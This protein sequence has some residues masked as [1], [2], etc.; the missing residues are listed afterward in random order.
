MLTCKG[1]SCPAT[2][3]LIRAI[4]GP[5]RESH[6][7]RHHAGRAEPHRDEPRRL[8]QPTRPNKPA[9]PNEPAKPHRGGRVRHR[10][11]PAR[12]DHHAGEP[13]VR[14]VLRY[15][16]RCRRHPRP[17]RPVHR[18]RARPAHQRLRQAVP[19]SEPGERRSRPQYGRRDRRHRR[20]QDGRFRPDRRGP[21]QPGLQRH[22]PADTGLPA[23]QP[24]L[25]ISPY[26]RPGYIDHQTLSF[27]A[28]NK[29]IEDDFLGGARLDPA[30][31]GRPDPRPDVRENASIL[32]NLAAD[33]DFSQPPRP[34]VLL[35]THPEPGPASTPG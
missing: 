5:A 13:V 11:D 30:T 27:D 35:P 14:L 22:Q 10:Q 31:D 1:P 28:Y 23:R 6:G 33:F 34:A 2:G 16:S 29:F 26:A 12:G 24:A 8:H 18:V 19:R 21:A 3:G 4:R 20:R 17:E 15:L 32:G 7:H 25:V 9:G